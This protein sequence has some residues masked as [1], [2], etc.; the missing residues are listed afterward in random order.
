MMF[1]SVHFILTVYREGTVKRAADVLG[2]SSPS[3]YQRLKTAEKDF[4]IFRR[5][6]KRGLVPTKRGLEL[7]ELYEVIEEAVQQYHANK[8]PTK[9]QQRGF[10]EVI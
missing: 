3:V 9:R 8:T 7:I 4:K 2:V 1:S 6:G 10:K 5:R